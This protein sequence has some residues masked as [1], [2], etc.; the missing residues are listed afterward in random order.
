[1][2]SVTEAKQILQITNIDLPHINLPLKDAFNYFT[3]EDILSP[4]NLPPFDQSAMD[5]YAVR[6]DNVP[7][8]VT[9]SLV[10]HQEIQ[11]GDA[12]IISMK[13]NTAI[14]IFTG[15][16]VPK[17]ATCVVVQE[18]IVL[19]NDKIEFSANL[20]KPNA[21]IRYQS[22]VLKASHLALPKYSVL[23][24]AA[25]GLLASLGITDVNVIAKPII[26]MIATG[27]ELTQPG[28][29]L[30]D[31][32]I[33]ESNTI[34]LATAL[35]QS[36]FSLAK[37][38]YV[39]DEIHALN[40]ALRKQ[41]KKADILIISGGISVG[42][43]DLVHEA[44]LELGVEE[45]FYKIAQKPGKPIFVGHFKNKIVFALPGNPASI[46][47]CFYEYV[48]PFLKQISGQNNHT[49]NTI[50][51][52]TQ[53][54]LQPKEDRALF[55]KASINGTKLELLEGQDSNILTSFAKADALVY[56]PPGKD[57]I[58]KESLVEVHLLPKN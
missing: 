57:I 41:I 19:V 15:A 27:N 43:Y 25:I 5:G 42:K 14:R 13:N 51:L 11:A 1:M 48:L 20:L 9:I 28:K 2:I 36:G 29:P 38:K 34:M 22:S 32:K 46:L 12:P 39:K 7:D 50:W 44:L 21:N 35:L 56:L 58:P 40:L 54:D 23:N 33:Y 49:S 55:L 16:P 45:L 52:P 3:S 8:A 31:G 10:L 6:V 18:Q 26:R 24:P 17:N 53:V 47:V 30:E 37:L 4:I